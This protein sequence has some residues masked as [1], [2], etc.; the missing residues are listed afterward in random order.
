M[1]R[2]DWLSSNFTDQNKVR[3]P[4]SEMVCEACCY[5]CSWTEPPGR[6]SKEGSKK[7]THWR[8][9]S[10]LW[11]D[12]WEGIQAP[13]YANAHKGEKPTIR[14]FIE[15]EHQGLW[16]AAI[17]DSGKKHVIPWAKMN[18][19]G[20]SGIVSLDDQNVA[21][22]RDVSLVETM[23]RLLTLG[24]SKQDI[25]TG[26]YSPY[27]YERCAKE[28]VE[29][30]AAEGAARN[31]GWFML[32]LWLAQRDEDESKRLENARKE[33]KRGRKAKGKTA[34][35]DGRGASRPAKR[36][37]ESLPDTG[38]QALGPAPDANAHGGQADSSPRG[39]AQHHDAS[40]KAR[41][42]EQLGL[43]GD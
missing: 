2:T 17:T 16:F 20:R 11:E 7:G 39:V 15:R 36:V 22:P 38:A 35:T 8:M 33:E 6:P 37:P 34:D 32:A 40:A 10:H 42:A 27:S 43:F 5:I 23:T 19:R 18:A 14:A 28:I 24:A 31:S 4:A 25:E 13:G 12:G 3:L 1:A 9:F 21:V 30:E 41:G 26:N 29:F